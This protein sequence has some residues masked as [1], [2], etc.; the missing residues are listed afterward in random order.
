MT[1]S[2]FSQVLLRKMER[3]GSTAYV[4]QLLCQAEEA[5]LNGKGTVGGLTS[6]GVNGKS[7]SRSIDLNP[8]QVMDACQ[9]ALDEYNSE[10]GSVAATYADFSNI[11]R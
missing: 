1:V 11:N 8:A 2:D 9:Q 3:E 4:D 10:G 7:F 5:I 6:S